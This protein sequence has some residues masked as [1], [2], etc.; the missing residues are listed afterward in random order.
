MEHTEPG[1][2]V[3]VFRTAVVPT[4]L[5]PPLWADLIPPDE[6]GDRRFTAC[7]PTALSAASNAAELA[8]GGDSEAF[9]RAVDEGV[10]ANLLEALADLMGPF[11]E[12]EVDVEWALTAPRPTQ[13]DEIG[14]DQSKVPIFREA[15]ATFRSTE[16]RPDEILAGMVELLAR[17]TGEDD[18]RVRLRTFVD[19]KPVTVSAE[20][21]QSDYELAVQ[22]H[23][24]RVPI[25]LEGDLERV[26]Q[27]WRLLGAELVAVH[28]GE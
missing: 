21:K 26:G 25:S 24:N 19:K 16:P 14:F 15:A 18:G 1:S 17:P 12:I 5:Q 2:F 3:L 8:A 7:L 20:L 13:L 28:G 23:G 10:S 22:S 11:P 4:P 6:P 27:R 9:D